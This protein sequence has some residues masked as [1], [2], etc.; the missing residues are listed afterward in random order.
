MLDTVVYG[1]GFAR[2]MY[3]ILSECPKPCARSATDLD[4]NKE[5]PL[6]EGAALA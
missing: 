2:R 5:R 1:I 3:E 4:L 6:G